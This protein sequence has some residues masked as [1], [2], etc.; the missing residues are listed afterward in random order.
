MPLKDST[1]VLAV[2]KMCLWPS[3]WILRRSERLERAPRGVLSGT[4]DKIIKKV[5]ASAEYEDSARNRF[6]AEPGVEEIISKNI[7]KMI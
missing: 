3:S 7:I 6:E 2:D 5:I 4:D 1:E